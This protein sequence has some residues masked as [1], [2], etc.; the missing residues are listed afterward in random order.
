MEIKNQFTTRTDQRWYASY[1]AAIGLALGCAGAL[2]MWGWLKQAAPALFLLVIILFCVLYIFLLL[3]RQRNIPLHFYGN[4]LHIF[5]LDGMEYKLEGIPFRVFRFYQNPLE[6]KQNVGRIKIKGT[7]F[8][9]YGVQNYSETCE[10]IRKN[11]PD[12]P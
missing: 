3:R 11:F 4:F 1:T 6:R 7:P 5:H 2:F 8:Y 10:Y 12:S 9:F